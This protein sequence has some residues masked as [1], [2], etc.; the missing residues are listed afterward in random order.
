M[1]HPFRQSPFLDTYFNTVFKT[2]RR[3][4]KIESLEIL[5]NYSKSNP[6]NLALLCLWTQDTSA[7]AQQTQWARHVSVTNL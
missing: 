2:E 4:R 6:D 7:P 3:E 1:F 5:Q